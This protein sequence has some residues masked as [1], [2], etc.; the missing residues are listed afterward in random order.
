M[1][2]HTLTLPSGAVLRVEILA[3]RIARV[4]LS[5]DG[6]FPQTPLIRYGFF[7]GDWPGAGRRTETRREAR[8]DSGRFAVVIDK[9]S[10]RLRF[11]DADGRALLEECAAPRS[12]PQTGFAARF[13]AQPDEKF[14]GFGDQTRGRIEH[15]GATADMWVRNVA[16]YIPVSFFMST[17]GYGLCVNTTFRHR[18]DMCASKPDEI[19][20]ESARGR[21]DYYFFY[22]PGL[23]ELL[24]AYTDLT[25]KPPLPPLFSFGLWFLCRIGAND[26]EAVDDGYNFRREEM[27]CDIV[28]LEPGWME[29]H[30]DFST[31]KYW[32]KERFPMADYMAYGP[33]TF[34]AALKRMGFKLGLWECNDYDLSFEEERR[35][36]GQAAAA[37]FEPDVIGYEVD[38]HLAGQVWQD[39][40]TRPDEPWFEHHK[41]FID[42]GVVYFKQDGSKQVMEHPDRLYGNGMTDAE[43]HN[44]YPLLYSK[45]M[46]LGYREHTGRRALGFTSGGFTGVQR[47]TG[48]WTGDTGGGPE[49]L[50]AMLNLGLSGHS[51][52]TCDM[53]VTTKEGIHFGFLQPWAQVNSWNYF[54][55]PWLLGD[56]LKPV[57]KFYDELRYRLIPFFYSYARV[58]H[59]TG[60]PI[61]RAMPLAFPDDER[62]YSLLHEYMLGREFLVTAFEPTVYLPA[63]EWFDYWT[64]ELHAGPKEFE[65]APPAGRGGGLFVRAGSI[66]PMWP[67]MQYV[68]QK[69]VDEITL[70][71]YPGAA[72]EFA[73]YEDDGETYDYER[74][75]LATT[76]LELQPRDD[77]FELVIGP[78]EGRYKG[79]PPRPAFVLRALTARTPAQM[80]QDGAAL[81]EGTEWRYD[82][83]ARRAEIHARPSENATRV[84]V[85]Y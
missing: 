60:M 48:T 33:H 75:A 56:E 4:R 66:I 24:D 70:D 22:G 35:L 76:R 36:K 83:Q 85:V 37:E 71:L 5:P 9:T 41:K 59:L 68:G 30:Y 49:P 46:H 40:L 55:H 18:F 65:Y 11:E 28:Q 74:G 78:R 20:F 7:R 47:Y 31:T 14:L 54:R 69:P 17:R 25:G 39:R 1:A 81:A 77:G 61:L 27:P 73:L 10:G 80:L 23:P 51:F 32:S 13:A 12:D 34:I 16:S 21:L 29:K 43:M 15:R 62:S 64:G 8:L 50:V 19:G 57:F 44:L 72:A 45:Q 6:K 58:S 26:R 67:L 2:T 82:P 53:E 42:Q 84:R 63:G 52:V 79:M 3:P 38:E